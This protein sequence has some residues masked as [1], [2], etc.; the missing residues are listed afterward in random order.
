MANG[1]NRIGLVIGTGA[2]LWPVFF[3]IALRAVDG[4]DEPFGILA[5]L[6]VAGLVV[7]RR[8]TQCAAP[9]LGAPALVLLLYAVTYPLLTPLPRGVLAMTALALLLSRLYFGAP[10]NLG[11]W[12]LL[13]LGLPLIASVQFYLGY[14]LR[15][16]VAAIT[17]K[18][19]GL[20]GLDVELSG[21][22]LR[23]GER[24][25]MVDA[26]CSGIRMLWAGGFAASLL[27]V[28]SRLSA[29]ATMVFMLAVAVCLV[30]ANVLRAA[31]LFYL[32]LDLVRLPFVTHEG[33]GLVL[34]AL[35]LAMI[36]ALGQWMR[37]GNTHA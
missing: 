31:A 2:A 9:Q 29:K 23:L 26:P 33:V 34:F 35:A 5:L 19:L 13:L 36:G 16:L 20:N 14:P 1:L 25:V 4:S 3:W 11:L 18:F 6:A 28:L 32:E 10:L 21:V 30:L 24:V 22:G 37:R 7:S 15:V 17:A 27:A 8:R 12:G